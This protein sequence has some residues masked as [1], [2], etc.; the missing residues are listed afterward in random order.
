MR[1][2]YVYSGSGQHLSGSMYDDKRTRRVKSPR[3]PV[4]PAPPGQLGSYPGKAGITGA[5]RDLTLLVILW[6]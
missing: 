2:L 3:A 6:S 5:Q 4:I 1:P